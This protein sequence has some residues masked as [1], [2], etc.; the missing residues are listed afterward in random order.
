MFLDAGMANMDILHNVPV[1]ERPR[2]RTFIGLVLVP[3]S[4]SMKRVPVLGMTDNP[5]DEDY[6]LYFAQ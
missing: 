5:Q 2:T 6:G 3:F 1:L 4:L